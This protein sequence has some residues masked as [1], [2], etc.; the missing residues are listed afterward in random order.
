MEKKKLYQAGDIET[1]RYEV[2]G[3]G[4]CVC[5]GVCGSFVRQCA[6]DRLFRMP[7]YSSGESLPAGHRAACLVRCL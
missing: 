2:S 1:I 6:P 3:R 5:R 7:F 4:D